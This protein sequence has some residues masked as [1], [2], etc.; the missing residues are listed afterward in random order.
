MAAE[1]EPTVTVANGR[2]T[3]GY[4]FE[5][6]ESCIATDADGQPIGGTYRKRVDAVAAIH[7]AGAG[8]GDTPAIPPSGKAT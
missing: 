7:R 6:G 1:R 5:I 2:Q 3:L 4:V 8:R